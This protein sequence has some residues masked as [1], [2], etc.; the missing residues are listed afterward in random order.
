[1]EISITSTDQTTHL[2]GVAVRVWDGVTIHPD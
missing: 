2:E 1:M